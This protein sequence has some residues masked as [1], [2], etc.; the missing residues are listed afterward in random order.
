MTAGD[1]DAVDLRHCFERCSEFHTS[2]A[3]LHHPVSKMY[4]KSICHGS[5]GRQSGNDYK[6]IG[7]AQGWAMYS[8]GRP[9]PGVRCAADLSPP[10]ATPCL[11][12][13][14]VLVRTV[15]IRYLKGFDLVESKYDRSTCRESYNPLSSQARALALTY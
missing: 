5:N 7:V 15:E 13:Y 2:N 10:A 14:V 9:D 11:L 12:T 4:G 3:T 8:C 6:T 1:A